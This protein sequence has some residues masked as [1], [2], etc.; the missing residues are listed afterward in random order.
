MKNL[1]ILLLILLGFGVFGQTSKPVFTDKVGYTSSQQ[2]YASLYVKK[3]KQKNGSLTTQYYWIPSDANGV[4]N[5]KVSRRL[6]G[7]FQNE[8][9][10]L[11]NLPSGYSLVTTGGTPTILI[12]WQKMFSH[13][14]VGKAIFEMNEMSVAGVNLCQI[15][16]LLDAVFYSKTEYDN[17]TA[18]RWAAYDA[19]INHA[20]TKF[21]YIS[22]RICVDYDDSKYYF[23]DP[24]TNSIPQTTPLFDLFNEIAQDEWGNPTRIAFGTGRGS[25]AIQTAKDKMKGFVTK[26]MNRY[27][28]VV[29]SK[30]YWVGVAT[31]AQ[32]EAGDN[33]E[34]Q[35]Y[36]DGSPSALKKADFDFTEANIGR[37]RTFV[38]NKYGNINAVNSAWNTTYTGFSQ[39]DAPRTGLPN[40]VSTTDFNILNKYSNQKG[41][42]WYAHNAN[43]FKL[44]WQECKAIVKSYNPNIKYCG[45]FGANTDETSI[46]RKTLNVGDITSYV[47]VLKTNFAGR[48]WNGVKEIAP[49]IIRHNSNGKEIHTEVN[50]NDVVT[51]G[52]QTNPT[53]VKS[54]MFETAK[55]AIYNGAKA[56][57]LID[58]RSSNY[59]SNT[60]ALAS[61][62]RTWINANPN[63]SVTTNQT[64]NVNL[65]D[66]IKNYSSVYSQ[67]SNAGGTAGNTNRVKINLIDDLGQINSGG[68][69]NGGSQFVF[70]QQSNGNPLPSIPRGNGYLYVNFPSH[71]IVASPVCST[72]NGALAKVEYWLLDSGGNTVLYVKDDLSGFHPNFFTDPCANNLA[73]FQTWKNGFVP[74][75]D[76]SQ[77][78]DRGNNHFTT[79]NKYVVEGN[80]TWRVKN[81][82]NVRIEVKAGL[83]GLGNGQNAVNTFVNPNQ[84][85]DFSV[86]ISGDT[87]NAYDPFKFNTVFFN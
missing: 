15:N 40:H 44:F 35:N 69:G 78:S 42:D 50:A 16:I 7:Y 65:S 28:P 81:N 85:I 8:S 72:P 6:N 46:L 82:G 9:E 19:I 66:M 22:F 57:I 75:G 37:F 18:S 73:W 14:D 39:I 52:G 79:Y 2:K 29:G 38:Q 21:Q 47:D 25:L 43:E 30:L 45:E 1:G 83:I 61:E 5:P 77:A 76:F 20:V 59:Y 11:S 36:T 17:N 48:G 87:N 49:D 64:M 24:P 60:L 67:W 55:S 23:L 54:E 51:Q 70:N 80:Y 74:F 12:G 34:N 68:G 63:V 41:V 4:Q 62:L 26:V 33:Y 56:V 71:A 10:A 32:Q 84:Q 3:T 86:N 53:V 31:S 13:L 58:D 27:Y